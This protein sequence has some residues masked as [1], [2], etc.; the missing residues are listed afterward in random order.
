MGDTVAVWLANLPAGAVV[1][2]S[3]PQDG[4]L[5]KLTYAPK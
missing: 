3:F 5:E 4:I 2:D 1:W